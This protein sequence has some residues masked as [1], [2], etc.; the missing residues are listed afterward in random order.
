M[1]A[2]DDSQ[3]SPSAPRIVVVVPTIRED[4]MSA[5]L[6]AWRDQFRRADVELIVVE[7]NPTR[8]FDLERLTEGV[9]MTHYCWQDID[10]A[11][12]ENAWIIPRRTDCV[13]SFGYWQAALRKP[14]MIVTLDDDCYP[15]PG[16]AGMSFFELHWQRLE[17]GGTDQAWSSSGTGTKP[18]G[19]PYYRQERSRPCVVNHGLWTNVPDFDAPTQLLQARGT[20]PF[21]F[22]DRTIPVGQYFP[23]CGMNLAFRP[24]AVPALYFL[25]MGKGEPYDRFGD[26]W[27][28]VFVKKIAD[29]LGW[30]INSGSPAIEHQRASNV[31][32]NLRKEAP[33]LEVNEDLWAAVDSVVLT[34]EDFATC[35][36]ELADCLAAVDSGDREYFQRLR[37]AMTIWSSLFQQQI[38]AAAPTATTP[39]AEDVPEPAAR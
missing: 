7:D 8:S 30:A 17:Q 3:L 12:G 4:C 39:A 14:D 37:E 1:S 28:G 6:D 36:A 32:A 33:G 2:S 24:E 31:W 22:D 5:F 18:R 11:L 27:S 21:V 29:H 25:L 34:G 20:T 38:P 10:A 19:I 9:R 15:L 13:R 26:I 35:Y 23:M 16:I